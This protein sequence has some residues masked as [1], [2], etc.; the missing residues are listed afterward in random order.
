M[1]GPVLVD[2]CVWVDH[3]GGRDDSIG[4]RL[5]RERV[6]VHE[7]ILGELLLGVIPRGHPTGDQ[8]GAL[9]RLGSLPHD[10]VV[11]FVRIH[12]LEGSGIG[13]VDAHVL[14]SALVFGAEVWTTDKQL[15][16]ASARV[17]VAVRA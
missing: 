15:R 10:E 8:L 12:R 7:F 4:P 16:K 3:L 2:T 6:H 13:W 9:P 1:S 14:A 5:L 17:G 11:Q